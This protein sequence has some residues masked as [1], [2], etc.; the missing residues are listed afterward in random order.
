MHSK[1]LVFVFQTKYINFVINVFSIYILICNHS[2]KSILTNIGSFFIIQFIIEQSDISCKLFCVCA[3]LR[4]RVAALY[5]AIL[6]NTINLNPLFHA[7]SIAWIW[8]KYAAARMFV[9]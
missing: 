6:L 7:Q 1:V 4:L 2:C 3:V 9:Q 8:H 5:H